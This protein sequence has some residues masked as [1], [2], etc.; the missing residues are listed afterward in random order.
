MSKRSSQPPSRPVNWSLIGGIVGGVVLLALLGVL[1][2][3]FSGG[4][5]QALTL[6]DRQA[7]RDAQATAAVRQT[8]EAS[9]AAMQRL[10]AYC[11]ANPTRCVSTGSP[12]APVTIYEVSD[13]GC[14]A[15]KLFNQTYIGQVRSNFIDPGIVRFVK[16]VSTPLG[17]DNSNAAEAV[18][19]ANDQGQGSVFHER[20]FDYM[21]SGGAPRDA[22]IT[23][24][25][26]SLG[27][28]MTRF[29]SCRNNRTYRDAVAA[30]TT[31][32]RQV[33]INSTPSFIVNGEVVVGAGYEPL[34]QAINAKRG[35][36]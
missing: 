15:C 10:D 25:A 19:C 8:A 23:T 34:A 6:G 32:V 28:D 18:L 21:V 7:T 4:G 35:G 20:I 13:Y 9:G 24:L 26:E 36:G 1:L 12:S 31:L 2:S 14:S 17:H 3:T 30:T 27:L 33:G 5:E 22:D 16:L 29:D 11:T